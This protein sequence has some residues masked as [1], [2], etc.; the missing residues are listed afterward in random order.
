MRLKNFETKF[1]IFMN[2][3]LKKRMNYFFN[4]SNFLNIN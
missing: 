1:I 3:F 2:K 4:I